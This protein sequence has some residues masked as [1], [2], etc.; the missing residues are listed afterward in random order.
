MWSA[1]KI[2]EGLALNGN[3][4][5]VLVS[6]SPSLDRLGCGFTIAAWAISTPMAGQGPA[7]EAIV[8]RLKATE[9]DSP[10][11][12]FRGQVDGYHP[13]AE[14]HTAGATVQAVAADPAPVGMWVH[15]GMTYDQTTLRLYVGGHEVVAMASPGGPIALDTNPILLGAAINLGVV[16]EHLSGNLDEVRIYDRALD[17]AAMA[18]LLSP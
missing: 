17:A 16:T 14:F 15:V 5:Y 8:S 4:Q 10:Y 9:S 11:L 7:Y 2:G 6:H 13:I 18:A 12:G 1:G 3:D